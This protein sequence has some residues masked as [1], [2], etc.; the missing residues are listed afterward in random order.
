MSEKRWVRI[1]LWTAVGVGI[2]VV[3]GALLVR[4]HTSRHRRDLFS[5]RLL[6]RHAALNYVRAHPGI[7]NVFL[8]RDYLAWEQRPSLR[9]RAAAILARMERELALEGGSGVSSRG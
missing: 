5:D 8:L 2:G 4:D 1:L 6:R 3:A 7:E 9:R